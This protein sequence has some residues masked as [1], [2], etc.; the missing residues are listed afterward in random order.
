MRPFG[1]RLGMLW[2]LFV[3]CVRMFVRN[4]AAVFFSLFLPLIIM[5]ILRNWEGLAWTVAIETA[6]CAAALALAMKGRRIE[7]ALKGVA[8]TPVRYSLLA[9]EAFTITRF[10]SDLWITNNRRWRK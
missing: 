7:Y 4:R 3:A 6:M 9:M 8:V 10:A 5:L 2:A 1:I